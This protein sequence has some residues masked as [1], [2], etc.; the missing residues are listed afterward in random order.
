M[1]DKIKS[2]VSEAYQATKKA[3]SKTVETIYDTGKLVK[4][5]TIDAYEATKDATIK[6]KDVVAEKIENLAHSAKSG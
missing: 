5:K 3:A 2:D 6:A 4:D 1:G